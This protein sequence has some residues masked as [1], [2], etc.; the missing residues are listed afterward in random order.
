MQLR[1]KQ[2]HIF[3]YCVG[4]IAAVTLGGAIVQLK[5][6]EIYLVNKPLD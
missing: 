2:H 6:A 4:K 3:P 1:D 5:V